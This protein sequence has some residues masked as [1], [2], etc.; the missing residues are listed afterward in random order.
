MLTNTSRPCSLL[1]GLGQYGFVSV[2]QLETG[3]VVEYIKG[4]KH[5]V[6]TTPE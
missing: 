3:T 5:H 2:L 4:V 1:T 6:R